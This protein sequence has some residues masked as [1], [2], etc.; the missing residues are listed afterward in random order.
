MDKPDADLINYSNGCLSHPPSTGRP[1]D[2]AVAASPSQPPDDAPR[3]GHLRR[4]CGES[5]APGDR[6]NNG[7]FYLPH[8][9]L[10][11]RL[12][13]AGIECRPLVCGSMGLQ[14][15]W[16]K[17][18]GVTHLPVADK[19]HDYGLYLPN[20]A[21]ITPEDIAYVAEQFRA[22]AQP[23][24]DFFELGPTGPLASTPSLSGHLGGP[25]GAPARWLHRSAA[26]CFR[27][28]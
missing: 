25:L 24:G 9:L 7:E 13:A 28:R 10:R 2:Q 16:I 27:F 20:H 14:P 23:I 26:S 17:K 1:S 21:N 5:V 4:L 11:V 8:V 15:F 18:Y 22:V 19:V 6:E 12:P 3:L